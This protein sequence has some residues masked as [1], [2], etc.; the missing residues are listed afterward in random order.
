VRSFGDLEVRLDPWQV[1]YG[2]EIAL[3][4][5]EEI[6]SEE[7]LALDIELKPEAWRPIAPAAEAPG[8]GLVFVDGVRR[9]EARLIVRRGDRLCHG[10]FGSYA[11]GAAKV[12]SQIASYGDLRVGRLVAIGGGESLTDGGSRLPWAFL[13]V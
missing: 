2:A 6:S 5:S 13:Q 9:I 3:E 8:P 12:A 4:A 7:I 10:A 1:D 11:V